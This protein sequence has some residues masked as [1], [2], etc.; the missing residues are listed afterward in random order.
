MTDAAQR[1]LRG[2]W[3]PALLAALLLHTAFA[4]LDWGFLPATAAW[5]VLF[6]SMRLREGRKAGRQAF[7]AHFLFLLGM[8]WG[9]GLSFIVPLNAPCWLFVSAWCAAFEALFA[10][11][12]RPLLSAG[13]RVAGVP[14]FVAAP[15]A[16]LLFD[17]LRTVVLTGF[18]W[19]LTGYAGWENPVLLAGA[20]ILGVHGA[21]LAILLLAAALAEAL[22]RRD[23]GA[24]F[25]VRAFVP[26]A[27]L[28]AGF[29][30][31]AL[32][33]PEPSRDHLGV[34]VLQA[35]LAQQ[36]KEDREA[37][38]GALPSIE[39]WWTIHER[40][41]RE[42]IEGA[43]ARGER[44]DVVVWPETMV[45]NLFQRPFPEDG[46]PFGAGEGGLSTRPAR[47]LAAS[48]KGR[49][50]LAGV[51][52]FDPEKATKWS[53]VRRKW[54]SAILMTSDARVVA[55]QDKR[56]RTP[57]GEYIPG[58]E[59]MPFRA[60][61]EAWMRESAGFMPDLLPGDGVTLLPVPVK[62]PTAD[63]ALEPADVRA[64]VLVCYESLFPAL[65]VDL[66]R[67]GADLI[68]DVS[69]YGWFAGTP[70]MEQALGHAA[71]RAA[72]NG[73]PFLLASNNGIS[74]VFGPVGDMLAATGADERSAFL[75]RIPV[76]RGAGRTPFTGWGEIPAW[77]LGAAGL[78]LSLAK[79][80]SGGVSA[81]SVKSEETS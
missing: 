66:A 80:R 33:R 81:V 58:L 16:H 22:L 61:F 26:A 67:A 79:R 62:G 31:L 34:L 60:S 4:P 70:L 71:F 63:G 15:L 14:W 53:E 17:M 40:L 38:G 1:F 13:G 77:V 35:N 8:P 39:E 29:G 74:A 21:T 25:S 76:D 47:R 19:H 56:H 57:G 55:C 42:G 9:G 23:A 52:T 37:S 10:R 69:N 20:P 27:V 46:P 64:G 28:W 72:E 11:S 12:M 50:T 49:P 65:S 45:P 48:S 41:A 3:G 59:Y 73:R 51:Q 36:L 68:V 5:A 43:E 75:V 6:A 30:G 24:G 54:N 7:V 78:V 44:V 18:P 2:F 32:A